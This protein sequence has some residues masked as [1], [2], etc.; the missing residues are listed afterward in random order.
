MDASR[1][2]GS[3][4]QPLSSVTWASG[5]AALSLNGLIYKMTRITTCPLQGWCNRLVKVLLSSDVEDY[6]KPE[7]RS[8]L[9]DQ[10]STIIC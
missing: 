5:V 9:S 7:K 8:G 3:A 4:H 6:I 2:T 10:L 1:E